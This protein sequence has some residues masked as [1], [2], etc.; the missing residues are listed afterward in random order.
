MVIRRPVIGFCLDTTGHWTALL[1]CGHVQHVRHDPPLVE[2]PWVLSAEGRS[3][4]LGQRL[5]CVRCG[6]MELPSHFVP[7][8]RTREWTAESMPPALRGGHATGAGTWARIVV[9]EGTL[10]YR[11]SRLG[12]DT[13]VCPKRD[14]VI[15]PEVGHSVEPSSDARFFL[16]FYRAPSEGGP[17]PADRR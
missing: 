9:R 8:Q 3:E 17:I 10:R 1:S 11:A 15:V 2:R 13:E 6:R 4:R 16:V 12:I 7:H 5:D 14:G